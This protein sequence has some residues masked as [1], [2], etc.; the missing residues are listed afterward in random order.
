MD[1]TIGITTQILELAALIEPF[2]VPQARAH[3][4]LTAVAAIY[5]QLGLALRADGRTVEAQRAFDFAHEIAAMR[6]ALRSE[7]V[8]D[9]YFSFFKSCFS[10]GFSL[11]IILSLFVYSSLALLAIDSAHISGP[12]GRRADE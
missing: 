6:P 1:G 5:Q 11:F 4:R 8:K 3:A 9:S 12:P 7:P 2:A 10:L